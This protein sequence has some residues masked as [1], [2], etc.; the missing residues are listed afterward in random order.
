MHEGQIWRDVAFVTKGCLRT[1]SIDDSGKVHTLYFAA[2][3]WWT[4]DRQ[5][6]LTGEPTRFN[7]DA[8]EYSEVV[9]IERKNFDAL[10]EQLPPFRDMI[11]VIL[12]KSFVTHQSR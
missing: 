10:C 2:E 12:Q 8:L 6:F 5:S 11:D 9:V 3:N 7:I 4:G 1:F